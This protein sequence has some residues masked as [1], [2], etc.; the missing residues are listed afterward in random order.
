M[1]LLKPFLCCQSSAFFCSDKK[2][3]A[4][5]V[6]PSMK[7]AFCVSDCFVPLLLNFM[8]LFY[9]GWKIIWDLNKYFSV[10]GSIVVCEHSIV[11]QTS[12]TFSSYTVDALYSVI[13]SSSCF[14]LLLTTTPL[15]V[16]MS[17]RTWAPSYKWR[18]AVF[19]LLWLAYFTQ[20]KVL[21]FHPHCH[22]L[23]H[24]LLL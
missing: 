9:C 3:T 17:S 21:K 13:S 18:H 23:L 8:Y 2:P 11:E 10:W 16:S 15:L 4:I 14:P 24:F 1:F 7:Y 5:L 6:V 19:V 22:I 20:Q 12:R